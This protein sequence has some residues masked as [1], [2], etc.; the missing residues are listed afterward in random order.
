MQS[1]QIVSVTVALFVVT[2]L[3]MAVGLLVSIEPSMAQTQD[4]QDQQF[5]VRGADTCLVCHNNPTV[6]SVLTTKHGNSSIPGSPFATHD[7]ESC[8]GASPNHV[9]ALQSPTVVFGAGGGLFASS[10]VEAQNQAC[11][12][13]HQTED[14][15]LWAA[16]VHES[17]DLA[18]V[19]CHTIHPGPNATGSLLPDI[20]T[21]MSCH[22]EKRSQLNRRSHHPLK[23]G[24]MTCADCHNPH[25]SNAESLLAKSTVNETCTTC[26]TE[27]RGPFLWEHQPVSEDCTTCHNPHG[28]TQAS[29]LSVRPP[30]LCQGCH[31][32]A[33]HPSTVYSGDDIPVVG[34][35]QQLLG[36][37]CTN[38]HTEVHG[39]N[40]PSGSRLTR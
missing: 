35:A 30:F 23:E 18:C 25:G 10:S 33:Y 19:S 31:S 36:S 32:E 11:L 2:V 6:T 21:C 17:A 34:A 29:M 7:C 8:H 37:A 9:S 26:H 20:D 22:L 38:C 13:C 12:S 5:A 40:H 4:T 15:V 24:L 1:K 39:S 16:S 3:S 28:T 27:K 14:R